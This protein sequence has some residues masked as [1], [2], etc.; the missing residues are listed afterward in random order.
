MASTRVHSYGRANGRPLSPCCT[1]L[2]GLDGDTITDGSARESQ[3]G[4]RSCR[5][6]HMHRAV[7]GRLCDRVTRGTALGGNT[8][9]SG[10]PQSGGRMN[11]FWDSAPSLRRR[12]Q[13][14]HSA[15]RGGFGRCAQLARLKSL[16]PHRL[17][18]SGQGIPIESGRTLELLAHSNAL[19]ARSPYAIF[20][21]QLRHPHCSQSDVR[22]HQ[23]SLG[24]QQRLLAVCQASNRPRR[25]FAAPDG[26]GWSQDK[27]LPYTSS[28]SASWT[29]TDKPATVAALPKRL[30]KPQSKSYPAP[31]LNLISRLCSRSGRSAHRRSARI[32]WRPTVYGSRE[33]RS[34]RGFLPRQVRVDAVTHVATGTVERSPSTARRTRL[35]Q[36]N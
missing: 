13:H 25:W 34:K 19:N 29:I 24:Y 3:H 22:H 9:S 30:S 15:T 36:L 27:C 21:R 18:R 10:R 33:S 1:R 11:A 17:T 6:P 32:H 7:L 14:T 23:R 8:A 16:V 4:R 35:S 5:W 31:W 20:T 28:G 2:G 12:W 26:T